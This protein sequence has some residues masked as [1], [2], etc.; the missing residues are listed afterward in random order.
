MGLSVG[1]SVWLF[2]CEVVHHVRDVVVP[3]AVALVV[4]AVPG[5]VAQVVL[6]ERVGRPGLVGPWFD[7]RGGPRGPWHGRPDGVVLGLHHLAVRSDTV[8]VHGH[9]G[10]LADHSHRG[11][12]RRSARSAAVRPSRCSS[13]T[14]R[15]ASHTSVSATWGN[16]RHGRHHENSP[17]RPDDRRSTE[18]GLRSVIA[19]RARRN[20]V[21]RRPYRARGSD[22]FDCALVQFDRGLVVAEPCWATAKPLD[23]G[24]PPR[25]RRVITESALGG[26]RRAP[27]PMPH[28]GGGTRVGGETAYR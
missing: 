7:G 20:P 1:L 11:S 9:A 25:G 23:I 13:V 18:G 28:A 19:A 2:S 3:A 10:D 22:P 6:G 15:L 21:L 4:V 5:T 26:E 17:A 12:R 27:R 8:T 16:G 24:K 14:P